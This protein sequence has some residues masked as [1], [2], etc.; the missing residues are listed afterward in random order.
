M[1][2]TME[3][4]EQMQYL[5]FFIGAEEYAISILKVKE[6]L[7][8][9]TLTRVP[10]TPAFIR[11]VINLR[12]RVVPVIDL[13]VRFGLG[14]SQITRRTCIVIVEVEL[15][16]EPAVMGVMADAVSQVIELRPDEIEEPPSF[17][18]R[19]RT[20]HLLGM[21]RAGKKFVLLLDI[22]QV[23][24][25]EELTTVSLVAEESAAASVTEGDQSDPTEGAVS[26][27]EA[28]AV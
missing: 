21:G 25:S 18:T 3:T 17:G 4:L 9:D 26:G 8:F 16:G 6:I 19:V 27:D 5:T 10:Q 28:P 2:A 14:D 13:A 15:E 11:G 22:D 12:G 20:D 23:L 1:S 24:S 7:E